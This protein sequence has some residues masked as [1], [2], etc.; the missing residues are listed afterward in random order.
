MT[1]RDAAA[2]IGR[3]ATYRTGQLFVAVRIVDTRT[4][5]GRD[6]AQIAPIE[7]SGLQWVQVSNLQVAGND[8]AERRQL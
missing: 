7:G 6:D 2:L 3:R 4:V 1:G 8:P 5:Y